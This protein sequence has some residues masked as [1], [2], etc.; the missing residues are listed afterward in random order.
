MLSDL[1]IFSETNLIL[2]VEELSDILSQRDFVQN[3]DIFIYDMIINV[4]TALGSLTGGGSS[5][6]N[7]HIR[8]QRELCTF[9]IT[10]VVTVGAATSRISHG[11]FAGQVL[12]I[13]VVGGRNKMGELGNPSVVKIQV[14]HTL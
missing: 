3:L 10:C 5:R 9:S 14:L 8:Y 4:L 6:A 2:N 12:S 11:I 13:L 7:L 1:S